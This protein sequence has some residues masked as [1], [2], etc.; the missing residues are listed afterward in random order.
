MCVCDLNEA[1]DMMIIDAMIYICSDKLS[2]IMLSR[3]TYINVHWMIRRGEMF[4]G[5]SIHRLQIRQSRGEKM[6][7]KIRRSLNV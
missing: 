7:K 4:G 1:F 5:K 2:V 6:P 3:I